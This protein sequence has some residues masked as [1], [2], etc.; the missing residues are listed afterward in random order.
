MVDESDSDMD[1]DSTEE[2]RRRRRRMK[3]KASL[4]FRLPKL[5]KEF[6]RF[7]KEELKVK[8]KKSVKK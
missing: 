5:R 2:M 7:L 6:K 3:R 4:P 8:K 1:S